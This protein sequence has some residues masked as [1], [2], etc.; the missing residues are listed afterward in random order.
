MGFKVFISNKNLFLETTQLLTAPQSLSI[1]LMRSVA[2]H[3]QFRHDQ[4]RPLMALL[5]N[6]YGNLRS[7]DV[8][9]FEF[10]AVCQDISS[11][12]IF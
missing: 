9:R 2:I 7:L 4:V 6:F 10:S 3:D 1:H 11:G 5:L 12:N 8:N